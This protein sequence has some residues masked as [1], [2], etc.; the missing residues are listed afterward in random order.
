M[1]LATK[2]VYEVFVISGI[3]SNADRL[4]RFINFSPQK[5]EFSP[6][7][8]ELLAKCKSLFPKCVVAFNGC[9]LHTMTPEELLSMKLELLED[10]KAHMENIKREISGDKVFGTVELPSDPEECMV[11]VNAL[12]LEM[13]EKVAEINRTIA[14]IPNA[15]LVLERMIHNKRSLGGFNEEGFTSMPVSGVRKEKKPKNG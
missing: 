10:V 7:F 4:C 8:A 6:Q 13:V 9:Q 1:Q 5:K 3:L 2:P 11:R 12:M 14:Q 15:R